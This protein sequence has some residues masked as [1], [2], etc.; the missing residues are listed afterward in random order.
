MTLFEATGK[1]TDNLSV[2]Y[3]ALLSIP[4]TSVQSERVFSMCSHFLSQR[5]MKM[6]DQTLDDLCLVKGNVNEL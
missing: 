4:P 5:R 1:R 2:V 6:N 3:Q